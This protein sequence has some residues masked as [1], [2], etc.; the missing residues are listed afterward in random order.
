MRAV[1][2]G[3]C[4]VLAESQ[5]PDLRGFAANA[6]NEKNA[7]NAANA[8]DAEGRRGRRRKK[9]KGKGAAAADLGKPERPD[10]VAVVQQSSL[11][12]LGEDVDIPAEHLD[13]QRRQRLHDAAL[14]PALLRQPLLYAPEP[15]RRRERRAQPHVQ[16]QCDQ[17]GAEQDG[18][19]LPVEPVVPV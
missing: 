14:E 19:R 5:K 12:D 11:L 16:L 3:Q 9:K 7:A 10:H 13:E 18:V 6:A 17:R 2:I 1:D 8:T 4:R 15:A